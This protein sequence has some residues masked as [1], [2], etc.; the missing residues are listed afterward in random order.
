MAYLPVWVPV[1]A[2]SWSAAEGFEVLNGGVDKV[3]FTLYV[4]TYLIRLAAGSVC[5]SPS[6]WSRL[7]IST[8]VCTR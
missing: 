1:V 4:I 2:D 5:F 6:F 7:T 3:L 8:L